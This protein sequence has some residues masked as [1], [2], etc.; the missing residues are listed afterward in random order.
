MCSSVSSLPDLPLFLSSL[1]PI[2]KINTLCVSLFKQTHTGLIWCLNNKLSHTLSFVPLSPSHV[3]FLASFCKLF[4]CDVQSQ[5]NLQD[6][7]CSQIDPPPR[8]HHMQPPEEDEDDGAVPL[9]SV[10][11]AVL[12]PHREAAL[13]RL[14]DSVVVFLVVEHRVS[15]AADKPA[16]NQTLFLNLWSHRKEAGCENKSQVRP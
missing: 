16:L 12:V 11:N 13:C 3:I 9:I 14:Q 5:K 6:L 10:S 4:V 2:L 15:E 7:C 1:A 8:L